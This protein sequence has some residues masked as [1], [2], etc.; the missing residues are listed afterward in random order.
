MTERSS[1]GKWLTIIMMILGLVVIGL[2]ARLVQQRMTLQNRAEFQGRD[3]DCSWT[4][5]LTGNTEFTVKVLDA[6]GTQTLAEAS[7]THVV[8]SANEVMT[9]T[10]N[11]VQ[12]D[13]PVD[14]STD[15]RCH[16][17]ATQLNNEQCTYGPTPPASQPGSCGYSSPPI[18]T[19]TPTPT[20]TITPTPTPTDV[21]VP[22]TIPTATPSLTPTITPTPPISCPANTDLNVEI[23]CA[24]C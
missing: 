16:V 20:G 6:T 13:I 7:Y 5:S 12:V 18:L 14:G 8:A 3:I 9:Y 10:F 24:N 22:T 4:S 1:K 19:N 2:I 11:N 15:V 17:A 21:L 23:I